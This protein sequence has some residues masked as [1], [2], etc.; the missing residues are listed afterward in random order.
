MQITLIDGNGRR[1]KRPLPRIVY[2]GH[3]NDVALKH[4]KQQSGINFEKIGGCFYGYP[5]SCYQITKLFLTYNFKTKRCDN[6]GDYNTLYLKHCDEAGFKVNTLCFKCC[7]EN[8]VYT[9]NMNKKTR[10]SV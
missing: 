2:L 4:I 7:K 9:G 8:G 10:L 5:K 1:Y 6:L 3:L